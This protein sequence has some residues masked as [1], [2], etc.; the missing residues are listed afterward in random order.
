[1]DSAKKTSKTLA[2]KPFLVGPRLGGLLQDL[3]A[4]LQRLG[5]GVSTTEFSFFLYFFFGGGEESYF[6]Y[7]FFGEGQGIVFLCCPFSF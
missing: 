4:V 5:E 6:F 2:P 3:K 7:F 1:M